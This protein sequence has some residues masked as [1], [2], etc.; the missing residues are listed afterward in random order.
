MD[1]AYREAFAD[2]DGRYR[3]RAVPD[4]WLRPGWL[5]RDP[6]PNALACLAEI[7]PEAM[8]AALGGGAED[9]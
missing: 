7:A 2:P 9:V 8:R 3:S 6:L 1:G 4:F 5:R